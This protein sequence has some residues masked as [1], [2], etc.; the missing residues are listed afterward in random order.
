[1]NTENPLPIESEW[2]YWR[3]SN[4]SSIPLV[5]TPVNHTNVDLADPL[6]PFA[7]TYI[8]YIYFVPIGLK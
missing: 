5:R 6:C 4:V 7:V 2:V 8:Y 3:Q 1:M